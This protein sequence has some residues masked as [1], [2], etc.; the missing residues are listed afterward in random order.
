MENK[1]TS[2][3]ELKSFFE[4]GD[5][6]TQGQFGKLIDSLRH[7]EDVLTNKEVAI[8]ANSLAA[9]ENGY[10]QYYASNVEDQK[11]SFVVNQHDEEDQVFEIGDTKG[12]SIKKYF[13]GNAPYTIKA[14]KFPTDGL[15]EYEYYLLQY[16]VDVNYQSY[17]L[18][19]NNL[20]TIEEG[21]EFGTLQGKIFPCYLEK[22]NIGQKISI[23]NTKINFI[24]NTD[25]AI[26]YRTDSS[27]WSGGYKSED[28]VTDHYDVWDYLTFRYSAD[29]REIDKSV[30]CKVYNADNEQLLTTGYLYAGQNNQ[31]AWGAQVVGV[32]NV[33]IECNYTQTPEYPQSDRN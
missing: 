28:S 10:I 29:L 27:N 7:K 16:Q 6:P 3:E 8:L 19:G 4:A 5:Y 1:P 31:N 12:A 2:R 33:R 14:K 24:N 30:E 32:R 23:V 18:F 9:M 22:Y 15:N 25:V 11:F 13:F 20:P 21:F 26:S 17:K